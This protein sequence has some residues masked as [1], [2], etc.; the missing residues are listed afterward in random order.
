MSTVPLDGLPEFLGRSPYHRLLG[1][2]MT[3]AAEG[4]VVVRMPFRE[5]LLAGDD[6][7]GRYIHGGA[8]ASLIDTAADFAVIAAVG[9]DVPT[10]DLRVDYLRAARG[11][12]IATARTR[13]AG[14][15]VAVADV[16]VTDD[17][18]RLVAVG[19]GVFKT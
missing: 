10:I 5:D 11:T 2:H 4:E 17:A 18:G 8:I 9:R 19:R 6:E 3:K 16:E 1:L 13:K 12:L 7:S 15:S 14:R